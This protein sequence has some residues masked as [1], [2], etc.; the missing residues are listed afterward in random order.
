MS[1]ATASFAPVAKEGANLVK[2]NSIALDTSA[3]SDVQQNLAKF[4]QWQVNATKSCSD[5]NADYTLCRRY[6]RGSGTY[7]GAELT[8]LYDCLKQG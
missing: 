6:T 7:C 2:K 4:L 3:S 5:F 8:K 1:S